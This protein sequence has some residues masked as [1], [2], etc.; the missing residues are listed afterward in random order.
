MEGF[1]YLLPAF[2]DHVLRPIR[3]A[4]EAAF[5]S[6]VYHCRAD[7]KEAG[8]VMSEMAAR[9]HTEADMLDRELRRSLLGGSSLAFEAGGLCEAIRLLT[10]ANINAYHQRMYCGVN[11]SVVVGGS[12]V[13]PDKV[14]LEALRPLL[15]EYCSTPNFDP[16][17]PAWPKELVLDPLLSLSK[18]FVEFP[19]VDSS[20]GTVS[21]GW[22]LPS[23]RE[24]YKMLAI[25]VALE[26]LCDFD[27]SPLPQ[28]F[29]MVEDPLA[30]SV[31][32][33]LE[34]Y[35]DVSTL[36]MTLEG[37]EHLGDDDDEG[38][39]EYEIE[40]GC[41]D[42]SGTGS[43]ASKEDRD[44]REKSSPA[45]SDLDGSTE[46]LLASGTVGAILID[47]LRS[48]VSSEKLPGGLKSVHIAIDRHAEE[49]LVQ[50][51]SDA[52]EVVPNALLDDLIYGGRRPSSIGSGVR[53][54]VSLLAR[55][56]DE[57]AGFWL[58]VINEFFVQSP[59]VEIYMI[60]SPSLA[61][62]LAADA[63]VDLEARR[64]NSC[65]AA[66][67]DDLLGTLN[68]LTFPDS[69]LPTQPSIER[70]PRI[71]YIASTSLPGSFFA[72]QVTVDSGL[73][74]ATIVFS[75]KCMSFPQRVCLP[76]L[77]ELLLSMDL[78]LDEGIQMPYTESSRA[79]SE[80]TVGT[81]GSGVWLNSLSSM[82]CDGIGVNYA[83]TAAKF[84]EAT[85]LILRAV[86]HGHVSGSRLSSVA[87]NFDS[88][89]IESMR[90]ADTVRAAASTLLP[91]LSSG[92][93]AEASFSNFELGSLFGCAPV[94]EFIAEEF[95]RTKGRK[96][97]RRKVLQLIEASLKS[98]REQPGSGIFV[99][100]G[101]R[102]PG[103]AME[104]F[105]LQWAEM[106]RPDSPSTRATQSSMLRYP[107]TS[108]ASLVGEGRDLCRALSVP[109]TETSHFQ[110]T[111]HCAV[112][113]GHPHWPSLQVLT[114]LMSRVEGVLYDAVRGEGFAYNVALT[115]NQWRARLSLVVTE[116]S[117]P[118]DAW[119]AACTALR[120]FR[121]SLDV[122]DDG[123]D[124]QADLATAKSALLYGKLKT[125]STPAHII[126]GAFEAHVLGTEVGPIADRTDEDCIEQVS[127][128]GLRDTFDRYLT[129]L[130]SPGARLATLS[131]G[132]GD[133]DSVVEAFKRCSV[134]LTF[135]VID[136]DECELPPVLDLVSQLSR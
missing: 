103:S 40:N 16:G 65:S 135:K 13:I 18:R 120:R 55:L 131:C 122:E 114:E 51:E 110:V 41:D 94:F 134:P 9:E 43:V 7:G 125:R 98:I 59:R 52:H 77:A 19:C 104:V 49:H 108:M 89:N 17:V 3:T 57:P 130:L 37:V 4:D 116:A 78:E 119:E 14:Y 6:E 23:C 117:L 97:V 22:R 50:I 101:A 45:K 38:E 58:S 100:I 64:V 56:R 62:R 126:A 105:E 112:A 39:D 26:W 81:G 102:N 34:V 93:T 53:E 28:K 111:V 29:V 80:A 27:S 5:A 25:E 95:S 10:P 106:W 85:R 84:E 47:Y 1:L 123:N 46:S 118:A 36:C 30:S 82:G 121:A 72:Q 83:A 124:L 96:R 71:P 63:E 44:M 42:G 48:I 132:P 8:V 86:F 109:G 12:E 11:V 69:S 99:Q 21:L 113:Q 61:D 33:D 136:V 15:D 66:N 88:D 127:L 115:Q 90:D 129:T 68:P 32:Y 31:D 2:L 107:R 70:V 73:V 75:T 79:I 76:I 20:M 60:P 67:I 87:K 133:V 128:R 54:R 35:L 91:R 74:H 24:S 92:R